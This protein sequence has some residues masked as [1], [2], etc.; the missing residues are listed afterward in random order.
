[1]S[2][3]AHLCLPLSHIFITM[4]FY[5]ILARLSSLAMHLFS[6]QRSFPWLRQT[7]IPATKKIYTQ[8]VSPLCCCYYFTLALVRVVAHNR[9]QAHFKAHKHTHTHSARPFR[10]LASSHCWT[11]N[12]WGKSEMGFRLSGLRVCVREC[13]NVARRPQ[14]HR[15][16]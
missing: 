8:T 13:A 9:W 12:E 1:M 16:R 6:K 5:R 2:H 4:A 14:T 11:S 7:F 15:L 10:R 3:I